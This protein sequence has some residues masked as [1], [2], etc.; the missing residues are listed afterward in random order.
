MAETHEFLMRAMEE[1]WLLGR[2]AEDKRMA[3]ATSNFFVASVAHCIYALTGIKRK[4]LPLT[5]W[6]FL[7]GIYG[8]MTS[9]KL[10]ERQQFHIHRARKL[11][12]RL[13]ILHPNEQV[14]ELLV[15]SEKEHKKQYPYLINLRLNA[16]WIGLH[17]TITL[18]GFFYS[19]KALIKK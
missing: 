3:I 18:L 15:K 10:Y 4:I 2:Q 19:I 13:D 7:S 6:M 17:I 16:L 5:L 8:I 14:E 1:N 12:A 11:R 9:L